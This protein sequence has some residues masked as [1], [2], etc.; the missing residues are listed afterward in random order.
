ME[1]VL[2]DPS[3]VLSA[4]GQRAVA[5]WWT[6]ASG[7]Y[8]VPTLKDY[9]DWENIAT[10]AESYQRPRYQ[11]HLRDIIPM[12]SRCEDGI[13][14]RSACREKAR[15]TMLGNCID[16]RVSR[17][18]DLKPSATFGAKRFTARAWR[19][20][21]IDPCQPSGTTATAKV[22]PERQFRREPR[23]QYRRIAWKQS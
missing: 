18:V 11:M 19:N 15:P 10:C 9:D 23:F 6:Y 5:E 13:G 22:R 8:C 20:I 14:Q 3:N 1:K 4:F 12:Q 21:S 17:R 7:C 16:A 2:D